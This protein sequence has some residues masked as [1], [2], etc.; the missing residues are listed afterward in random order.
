M[1]INEITSHELNEGPNDP[2]I[3]KAVFLA[4]GPGSGK[5]YVAGKLLS[6][7]GLK[8]V[9]SDDIYEYL[10]KKQDLDLSDP[11]QVYSD[12]GQEIRN[13]AKELTMSQQAGYLHGRLGLVI[14]GTGKNV[15]KVKKQSESLKLI[16]Y[17]TMMLF[18]NTSEDVAQA[19]NTQRARRLPTKVVN[20][21]W[22]QVQDNIMGFQQV[23]GASNFYVVD[24]SGGQEDPERKQNFEQIYKNVRNWVNSPVRNRQANAWHAVQA[25]SDK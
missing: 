15:D 13:R 21:M 22:S 11:D 25:K 6:G 5:S 3:F 7:F 2:H 23:F 14:D 9:N 17:E 19:R 4:G 24:N 18:V 1:L 10:A 16:G 20:Q 12:R 8:T